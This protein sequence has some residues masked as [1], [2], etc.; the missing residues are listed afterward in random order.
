VIQH[1]ARGYKIG[2]GPSGCARQRVGTGGRD[3]GNSF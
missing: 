3:K 2:C 1:T